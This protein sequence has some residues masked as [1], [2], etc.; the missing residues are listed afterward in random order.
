MTFLK[1]TRKQNVSIYANGITSQC[2]GPIPGL[3]PGAI[4][5]VLLRAGR[6]AVLQVHEDGERLL[7]DVVG[8]PPLDV[9]HEPE[10]AGVVLVARIVES[11]RRGKTVRIHRFILRR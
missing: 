2:I 9:H 6:A 5:G 4:P 8:L 10:A 1:V 7:D 11:L 3:M